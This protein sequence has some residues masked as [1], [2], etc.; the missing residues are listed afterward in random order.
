MSVIYGLK[1]C[2]TCRKLVKALQAAGHEVCLHDYRAD[3][4]D[5]PL[6]EEFLA[7]FGADA[8]INRRGTTW[9]Q[10]PEEE[11]TLQTEDEIVALLLSHPAIIKR[12]VLRLDNGALLLGKDA[13]AVATS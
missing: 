6:L 12:P 1:N 9:R 7:A 3:G 10:L 2:D 4:L 5:K 13:Q 11:K 8:L